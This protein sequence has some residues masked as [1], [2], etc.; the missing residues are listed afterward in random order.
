MFEEAVLFAVETIW[1]G[2]VSLCSSDQDKDKKA[3]L[4]NAD[5]GCLIKVIPNLPS[6]I[7]LANKWTRDGLSF[8]D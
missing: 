6:C 2:Y 5:G 7:S 3:A 1:A 4:M 8:S